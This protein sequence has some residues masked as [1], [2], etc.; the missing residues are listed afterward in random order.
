MPKFLEISN[1][2]RVRII[3][4]NKDGLLYRK[5]ADTYKTSF[6]GVRHIIMKLE[7]TGS[8]KNMTR[9][10]REQKSSAWEDVRI[11]RMVK[12]QPPISSREIA[13]H[14]NLNISD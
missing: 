3:E 10:G 13:T 12:Q 1:D 11:V 5:I 4:N 9:S 7:A 8:V 14:L 2:L 6:S